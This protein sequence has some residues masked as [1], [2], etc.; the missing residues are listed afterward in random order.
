M[1]NNTVSDMDMGDD[2]SSGVNEEHQQLY[3][4]ATL[5]D[6]TV[7]DPITIEAQGE[8]DD[9]VEV[10]GVPQSEL[11]E[12]LDKRAFDG[13]GDTSGGGEPREYDEGI[14][15][16]YEG[17]DDDLLNEQEDAADQASDELMDQDEAAGRL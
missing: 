3:D 5:T 6:D 9:P 10:L 1:D 8:S 2:D 4:D 13:T 12:E 7:I 11:K 16:V 15:E 17:T 14:N